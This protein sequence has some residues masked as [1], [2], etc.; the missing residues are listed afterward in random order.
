MVDLASD[1]PEWATAETLEFGIRFDSQTNTFSPPF[2]RVRHVIT[3]GTG[4]LY[5]RD[6]EQP[7]VM[8][9]LRCRAFFR[10]HDL[11]GIRCPNLRRLTASAYYGVER[12][13]LNELVDRPWWS[14]LDELG[15]WLPRPSHAL[16]EMIAATPGRIRI[17][18]GRD[19]LVVLRVAPNRVDVRASRSH[20][21]A[22][23][24]LIATL[25][26]GL[27]ADWQVEPGLDLNE[28]PEF[29]ELAHIMRHFFDDAEEAK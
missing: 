3:V 9:S 29:D 14:Q 12:H 25:Q 16:A 7:W 19:R 5:E 4:K 11:A 26:T 20:R 23:V 10:T 22:A 8:E 27:G 17:V 6:C 24:A 1:A 21:A 18:A 15:F 28:A 2:R 13:I